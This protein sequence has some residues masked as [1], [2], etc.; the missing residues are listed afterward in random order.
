MNKLSIEEMRKILQEIVG[1]RQHYI[2]LSRR[3]TKNYHQALKEIINKYKL[4]TDEP[5]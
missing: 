1:N 3:S 4:K 2:I 5:K